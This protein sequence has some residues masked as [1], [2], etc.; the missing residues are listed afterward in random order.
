MQINLLAEH[1][2]TKLTQL[3]AT[4]ADRL[5]VPIARDAELD[6]VTKDVAPEAVLNELDAKQD[7]A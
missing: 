3:V 4:I 7:Q 5:D 2:L 6:E 1:E